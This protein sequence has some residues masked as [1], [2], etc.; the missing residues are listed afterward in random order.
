MCEPFK[1]FV[2]RKPRRL[3]YDFHAADPLMVIIG[4][5]S[6]CSPYMTLRI[7]QSNSV[8]IVTDDQA[9]F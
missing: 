4:L 6:H 5:G 7:R 1:K 2:K 8:D 3:R 9:C